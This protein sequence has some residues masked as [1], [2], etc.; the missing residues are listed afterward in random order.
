MNEYIQK[1]DK[2]IKKNLTEDNSLFDKKIKRFYSQ[3]TTSN[4]LI[5]LK[6][7][8]K[9]LDNLLLELESIIDFLFLKNLSQ[10]N[11]LKEAKNFPNLSLHMAFSGSLGTG[12]TSFSLKLAQILRDLKYLT[13]G[14][15]ISVSREDLV[16]EYV[17]HTAPKTKEILQKAQGGILFIDEASQLYKA[18]NEKDYGSEAIEIILQVME[19]HRND[20][21]LIFSDHKLKLD[22]FFQANPGISSRIGHYLHFPNYSIDDLNFLFSPLLKKEGFFFFNSE[23]DQTKQQILL[24]ELNNLL[25]MSTYSNIRSL[26]NFNHKLLTNQAQR[27]YSNS[28]RKNLNLKAKNLFEVEDNDVK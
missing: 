3:S 18:N 1:N 20:L 21:A 25:Q 22:F 26:E 16:G 24:S 4:I 5:D 10:E 27:L 6:K 23:N 12:K 7:N 11:T 14:H 9:A 28:L 2:S 13:K 17:G 19:N 15:L 8:F